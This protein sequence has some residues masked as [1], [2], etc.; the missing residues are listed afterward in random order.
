MHS[1]K[2][3][4]IVIGLFAAGFSRKR[5]AAKTGLPLTTVRRILKQEATVAKRKPKLGRPRKLTSRDLRV[6]QR[7][8][9]K[10]RHTT[11]EEHAQNLGLNASPRTLNRAGNA[12]GYWLLVE[13]RKSTLTDEQREL[14]LNFCREH[15]AM[16][17]D[18][19]EEAIHLWIDAKYWRFQPDG[20]KARKMHKT[21]GGQTKVKRKKDEGLL[22]ECIGEG[23]KVTTGR[24]GWHLL[25]GFGNGRVC[26]T[27]QYVKMNEPTMLQLIDDEIRF[28]P[29]EAWGL[30]AGA[31]G[32]AY[33]PWV[34]LQDGDRSQNCAAARAAFDRRHMT[35]FPQWPP[36]SPDLNCI[37]NLWPRVSRALAT[38]QPQGTETRDAFLVR[39][40]ATLRATPEA[41]VRKLIRSMPE[42]MRSC[43][44]N[45]GGRVKY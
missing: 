37:E 40:K 33:R 8:I 5:V 17:A 14:R 24:K 16:T 30:Q 35:I 31:V 29:R 10:D 9:L 18:Q 6:L 21:A 45:D 1:D 19:W 41:F 23:S 12:L 34:V 11:Y 15:L 44:G 28:A 32:T 2:R 25:V 20:D 13:R 7:A 38:T 3:R 42:R 27:A 39:L 36:N 4:G 26:L 43:I 22:P